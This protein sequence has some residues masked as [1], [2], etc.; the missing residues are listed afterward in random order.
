[1]GFT[2]PISGHPNTF[3]EREAVNI[4]DNENLVAGRVCEIPLLMLAERCGHFIEEEQNKIL[5]DNALIDVLCN[6]VR[7][8]REVRDK[9]RKGNV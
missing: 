8:A 5:P 2:G 4:L 3:F 1:L 7:L 6:V 9:E